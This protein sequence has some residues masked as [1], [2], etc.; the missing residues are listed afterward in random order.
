MNRQARLEGSEK[1][2]DFGDVTFF[3][4]IKKLAVRS[5]WVVLWVC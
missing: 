1:W 2:T 3:Q 5:I 4:A